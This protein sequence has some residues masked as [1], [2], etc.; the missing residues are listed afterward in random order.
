MCPLARVTHSDPVAAQLGLGLRAGHR[1]PRCQERPSASRDSRSPS[2]TCCLQVPRWWPCR[3]TMARRPLPGRPPSPSRRGTSLSCC[4]GTPRLLGGRCGRPAP[5]PYESACHLH[6]HPPLI[7]TRIGRA[8]PCCP[9]DGAFPVVTSSPSAHRPLPPAGPAAADQEVGLFSQLFCE[10]LPGGWKGEFFPLEA[11]RTLRLGRFC[12]G[13]GLLLPAKGVSP[14]G[15][16]A[17]PSS[18]SWRA[19]AGVSLGRRSRL[20]LGGGASLG[21]SAPLCWP[22]PPWPHPLPGPVH[23]AGCH[24][25][26]TSRDGGRQV[27]STPWMAWGRSMA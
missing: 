10:A 11:S 22:C 21:C 15:A 8:P 24:V 17:D 2:A 16:P 5:W 27:S 26:W 1:A 9:H 23:H 19:A 14:S 4:E 7:Q 6:L 13:G 20:R 3:T 25:P 18:L 12:R